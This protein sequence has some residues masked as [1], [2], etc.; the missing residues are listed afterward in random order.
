MTVGQVLETDMF[1][2][3]GNDEC[4]GVILTEDELTPAEKALLA[5]RNYV[6]LPK[7]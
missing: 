5:G 1:V 4:C 2:L 6:I 7:K 3:T